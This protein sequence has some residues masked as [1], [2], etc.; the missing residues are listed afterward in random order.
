MSLITELKRRNVFRVGAA[1][2]IVGWLLVEVSS[3]F[4]PTFGA[5]DWVMKVVS[6]LV[7]L[8]FPL[9]V[10]L[11]W[12]FEL[13]PEGIKRETAVEPAESIR[14]ST[15]RKLNFAIIALLVV[16]LT[17]VVLDKYVFEAEPEG[18]HALTQ[19]EHAKGATE[20]ASGAEPA[21]REKSI[22]V[23]P[24]ANRSV[25]EED[26]FFVDGM[27]DDI[28]T[29]LAKIRSLKVISRTSVMEYRDTEKN[30]KTIGRELGAA[31]ILEGGVQRSGDHVRINM[32]L[33]DAETDD[34][35]WAEIFDRQL[36]A[37]NLFS[38]QT[39]IAT[40]IAEALRAA[41]SPEERDRLAAVPTE[42]L[43]AYEA[44][45]I[46]RQRLADRTT[47]A[48]VKAVEYF[49]RAIRLDPAFALAYVGLAEAYVLQVF[50]S[51]LPPEETL[52]KGRVAAEQALKLDD[53]LGEAYNA[54]A[55]IKEDMDDFKGAEAAYKR[56][57]ELNPNHVGTYHWYGYMLRDGGRPEEALAL[58]RRAIELDPLSGI[59]MTNMVG[60]L[61]ALGRY[62]EA[63]EWTEKGVDVVP[64]YPGGWETLGSVQW[65]VLGRL[66]DALV[67][68]S[69]AL[70][71]DPNNAVFLANVG[72]V[73]L[74]IGDPIRAEHWIHRAIQIGPENFI[75]NIA[76]TLLKLY[77]GD[78]AG[79]L[80][81]A[82][83]AKVAGL[84]AYGALGE[85]RDHALRAGRDSEALAP[86]EKS[87][88]ELLNDEDPRVNRTNYGAAIDLALI[89]SKAGEQQ[90]ANRLL[91]RSLEKIQT[92]ARRSG[93]GFG[94][95]DVQIYAIRGERKK[96]L[97]TLRQAIDE[98]WRAY[99][100]YYLKLDLS[101]ESLHGEPEFQ[102]MVSEIEAEM[103][104][105]LESVRELE[106]NGELAL[107]PAL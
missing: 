59:I 9:A 69:E 86:Y 62:D 105:Q 89:F 101:L 18:V 20:Q 43:E 61:L 31:S 36:T 8:G 64:N 13:T 87:Y 46:G 10:I 98:G 14:H 33:I 65:S 99:W 76:M 39:E 6:F 49:E 103:A 22:A 85:I 24:F 96:A 37:E 92:M 95:A 67:A 58:H 5:P 91:D 42:N 66:D 15:G 100:W 74:D 30:M 102:A 88:S 4:L 84:Y 107:T 82:R 45:L 50:Y 56:A 53:Q 25:K 11:A 70:A 28:L 41:L 57:L 12:A 63:M 29:H 97:S 38:I 81:Y 54:L 77:R 71:R 7:I 2:G 40:A 94:I 16:A 73:Y 90:R 23:L 93:Y 32:Q 55:A 75:S 78:E 26:A 79:A 27:H 3:V 68:Y 51:G 106:Q 19:A 21:G 83:R 80:E 1:Y 34:H 35:L 44:Y 17:Y 104:S 60:D 72:L 48:F 52:E 47:G